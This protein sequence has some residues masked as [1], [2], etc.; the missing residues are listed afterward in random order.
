MSG[1]I[2]FTTF[3][4]SQSG[5]LVQSE[6]TKPALSGNEVLISVTASGLCGGDLMFKGNDVRKHLP[7]WPLV[8][9]RRRS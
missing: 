5:E 6:T 3:R 7:P 1:G 8:F 2:K 4:G 9:L